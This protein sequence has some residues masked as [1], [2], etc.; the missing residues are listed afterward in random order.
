M[1]QALFIALEPR[2]AYSAL[3]SSLILLLYTETHNERKTHID[4]ICNLVRLIAASLDERYD[5]CFLVDSLLKC[6]DIKYNHQS[7]ILLSRLIF[8]CVLLMVPNSVV[9][10]I[11]LDQSKF[12]SMAAKLDQVNM[13]SKAVS[14]T[15]TKKLQ[16]VKKS[17]LSS[18]L[19][20]GKWAFEITSSEISSSLDRIAEPDYNSIL[21]CDT[22]SHTT[23]PNGVFIDI[24]MTLLFLYQPES[25]QVRFLLQTGLENRTGKAKATPLPEELKTRIRVCMNCGCHIDNQVLETVIDSVLSKKAPMGA[26]DAIS[27]LEQILY[28]CRE[29]ANSSILVDDITT[30]CSL[31]KL[32]TYQPSIPTNSSIPE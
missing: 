15:L 26:N 18:Y 6:T 14:N 32:A 5:G 20:S 2:L 27:L 8:E 29:D 24:L 25:K 10:E 1:L 4:D 16:T 31:F 19:L 7:L 3:S 21:D 22:I 28:H 9:E 23:R 30:I 12:K 11:S 17:I 13:M